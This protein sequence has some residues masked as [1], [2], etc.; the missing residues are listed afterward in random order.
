M[1]SICK[2]DGP[3]SSLFQEIKIFLFNDLLL[4]GK[5]NIKKKKKYH[6]EAQLPLKEIIVYDIEDSPGLFIFVFKK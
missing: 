5:C 2:L 3:I 1:E 4:L 6:L